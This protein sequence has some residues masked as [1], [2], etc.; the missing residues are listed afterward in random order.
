M[1]SSD[2]LFSC[3]TPNSRAARAAIPALGIL[4][5]EI[6]SLIRSLLDILFHLESGI[7]ILCLLCCRSQ[8]W[9]YKI[10]WSGENPHR[11]HDWRLGFRRKN[12]TAKATRIATTPGSIQSIGFG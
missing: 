2:I 1:V 11:F 8:S 6:S 10:L 4:F 7:F 5:L 9:N 12:H 3:N